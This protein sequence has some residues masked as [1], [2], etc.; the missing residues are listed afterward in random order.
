VEVLVEAQPGA[1]FQQR[2]ADLFGGAGV[3]GGFV[4]HQVAGLEHA[5]DQDARVAQRAKIRLFVCVDRGGHGHDVNGARGKVGR[6]D[7]VAR[8]HRSG[9]FVRRHFQGVV[10]ALLQFGHARMVDV[11][12]E[13]GLLRAER[14]RQRQADIAQPD[15]ADACLCGAVGRRHPASPA[16]ARRRGSRYAGE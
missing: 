2:H 11:V 4:D 1:G 9:E 13:R 10:A 6:V 8:L 5:A 14:Y 7:A 15:H 12:A 16:G 3:D